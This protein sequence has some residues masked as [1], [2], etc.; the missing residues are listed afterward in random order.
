M[1]H[2]GIVTAVKPG[3]VTVQIESVS[4]CASCQAHSKCGF[5]ESK[6]KTLDVPTRSLSH[7]ATQSLAVGDP[8]TVTIDYSRGLL[9]T[10]WAY[11]LPS[12]LIIAVIVTLSLLHLPE[13]A[14]IL[15]SLST[16]ALYILLLFLLR[17]KL[18]SRFTLTLST[19]H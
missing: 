17:H 3:F 4:A 13:P 15:L 2:P 7:S 18:D 6:T 10:W 19:N 9:A 11:I 14:V 16:L 5:A 12:I 1:T 8:V